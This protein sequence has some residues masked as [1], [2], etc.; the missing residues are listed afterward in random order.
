MQSVE[1]LI[2]LTRR[3]EPVLSIEV[4]HN[5]LLNL[6]HLTQIKHRKR[7]G[8]REQVLQLSKYRGRNEQFIRQIN[9]VLHST[10][11]TQTVIVYMRRTINSK[12]M[13]TWW[14]S[15]TSRPPRERHIHGQIYR[16]FVGSVTLIV[17]PKTQ[18]CT[19]GSE[20]NG[21][22]ER[23]SE[24]QNTNWNDHILV[25]VCFGRCLPP[26]LFY[27]ITRAIVALQYRF[28]SLRIVL[29]S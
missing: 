27:N 15:N 21:C 17:S 7:E 16:F 28:H 26:N 29:Y 11:L 24:K 13:W 14:E 10:A 12:W 3:I 23:K 18:S 9:W 6:K 1:G 8:E 19:K 25:Y 22:K 4:P 2:Y 20:H 5:L